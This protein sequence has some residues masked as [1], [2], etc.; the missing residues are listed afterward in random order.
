ML[1]KC[2]G[3]YKNKHYNTFMACLTFQTL[4]GVYPTKDEHHVFKTENNL[5]F[6]VWIFYL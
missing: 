5:I 6:P 3:V 2:L 4:W 1:W